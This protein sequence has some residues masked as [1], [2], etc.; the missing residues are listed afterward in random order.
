MLGVGIVGMQ[1]LGYWQDRS[2][3]SYL[4]LII[5]FNKTMGGYRA[6]DISEV[7]KS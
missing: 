1:L 7:T 6:I 3:D 2:I 4:G 5:Y